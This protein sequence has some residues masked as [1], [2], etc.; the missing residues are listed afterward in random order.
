[1]DNIG[2]LDFNSKI[3]HIAKYN[4]SN[5]IIWIIPIFNNLLAIS[6]FQ[7]VYMYLYDDLHVIKHQC[8]KVSQRIYIKYVTT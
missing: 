5:S 1:M 7:E 6:Q 3:I 2:T 4:I 8:G